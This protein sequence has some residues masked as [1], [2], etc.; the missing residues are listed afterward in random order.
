M[1]PVFSVTESADEPDQLQYV[2]DRPWPVPRPRDQRIT[3]GQSD[4]VTFDAAGK[5]SDVRYAM[6]VVARERVQARRM[7]PKAAPLSELT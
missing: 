6:S 1:F 4:I 3:I 5:P 2:P 7:T